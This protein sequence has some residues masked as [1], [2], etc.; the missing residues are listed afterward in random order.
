M[1]FTK[2]NL[3]YMCKESVNK[4]DLLESLSFTE[5]LYL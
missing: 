5:T 3:L 2:H 1:L 4:K